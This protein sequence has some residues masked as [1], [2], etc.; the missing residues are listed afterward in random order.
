MRG[1]ASVIL[2]LADRNHSKVMRVVKKPYAFSA[3][4]TATTGRRNSL[5]THKRPRTTACDDPCFKSLTIS[6]LQNWHDV[7][8]GADHYVEANIRPSWL[9]SMA[10]TTTIGSHDFYTTYN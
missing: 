10:K 1:V 6:V 7:T 9:K 4:N 8:Q 3:L 2:N 5:A